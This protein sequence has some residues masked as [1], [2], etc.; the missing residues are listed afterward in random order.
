MDVY[1]AHGGHKPH[2]AGLLLHGGGWTMNDRSEMAS[3][4]AF[5]APTDLRAANLPAELLFHAGNLVGK[6]PA[7]APDAWRDVSPI[8][9]IDAATAP[10]IFVHG[11]H[12]HLV[13]PSQSVNAFEA[14]RRAGVDA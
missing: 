7:V 3:L 8:A 2:P 1:P 12:D 4:V 10:T 5:F 9:F 14:M 6:P 13:P 11:T